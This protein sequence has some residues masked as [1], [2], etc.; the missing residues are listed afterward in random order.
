MSTPI[1]KVGYIGLGTMGAPIAANLLKAG[2]AVT[3]WNRTR[4]KTRA[5]VAKGATVADSL[6]ALAASGCDAIFL[7]V[8]D[9]PAVREVVLGASGLAPSLRAGTVIIDNS[10]IS[11]HDAQAV[12]AALKGRGVEFLDAPVSGGDVGAAAGTLSVM[13]GGDE[14]VYQRCLPLFQAIGK[15]ITHMGPVGMGQACKACNQIAAVVALM[16]VCEASALAQK[17]GLDSAKMLEILG[18]GGAASYQLKTYGAKIFAGDVKPG[19]MVR[20]MLKD[21]GIARDSASARGLP[22]LA[23]ALAENYL[24]DVAAHGGGEFGIQAMSKV[25][26]RSGD[27][28]FVEEK[29]ASAAVPFAAQ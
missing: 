16:G 27:F 10:T 12:A 18:G 1:K 5:L 17:L 2:F 11:A 7:N 25:L 14:V 9:G 28:H 24:C 22:L 20:L 4:A 21:L 26:E 15:T 8:N 3:V 6:A 29:P 19:F 23:T 13:V